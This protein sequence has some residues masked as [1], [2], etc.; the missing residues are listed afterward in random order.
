MKPEL[1]SRADDL[2]DQ[3]KSGV[4]IAKDKFGNPHTLDE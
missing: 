1:I 3:S 2:I 4:K